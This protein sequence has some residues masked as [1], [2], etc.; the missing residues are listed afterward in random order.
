ML[1]RAYVA[2]G[3]LDRARE[4]YRR[5]VESDPENRS[6]RHF[7]MAVGGADA[8][9]RAADDYVAGAFDSFADSFDKKL[10]KLDYRAPELCAAALADLIGA[11]TKVD[12]I[13]DAGCGT[14]LCG[15]LLRD[16]ATRL[17]GVDLSGGML[18]KARE[19]GGYDELVEA[20][21]TAFLEA[22]AGAFDVVLSADTLCYFGVLEG[23]AAAAFRSLRPG[24][25]LVFT[26]EAL[27]D[28]SA[29]PW[30]VQPNGR[31]VHRASYVEETLAAAGFA[32]RPSRADV[33]RKEMDLPVHGWIVTATRPPD[34]PA[35]A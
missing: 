29:A 30:R 18:A 4:I 11:T 17:V 22:R 31:Y 35:I 1:G 10:A 34:R 24:G 32:V 5:W 14:G 15:P 28:E 9:D 33:L 3:D 7:L 19:R 13:C 25:A 6:A 23:F 16:A 27:T 26:V 20:E 12:T 8:S 2:L 21:L